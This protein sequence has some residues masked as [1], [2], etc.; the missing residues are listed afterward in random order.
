MTNFPHWGAKAENQRQGSPQEMLSP[1]TEGLAQASRMPPKGGVCASARSEGQN[2]PSL[3][4]NWCC[5][6]LASLLNALE[7]VL[8]GWGQRQG[9]AQSQGAGAHWERLRVSRTQP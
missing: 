5:P 2:L 6:G 9:Q 3:E 8:R 7:V 1:E 4:K